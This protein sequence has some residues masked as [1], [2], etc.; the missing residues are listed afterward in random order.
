MF[1]AGGATASAADLLTTTSGMV[2]GT[3]TGGGDADEPF[4]PGCCE[5][6]LLTVRDV[7]ADVERRVSGGEGG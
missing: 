6:L 4:E 1:D 5:N 2:A 3:A 7:E